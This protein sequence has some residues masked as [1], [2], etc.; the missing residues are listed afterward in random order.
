MRV[1]DILYQ[2]TRRTKRVVEHAHI[3]TFH[4]EFLP[5]WLIMPQFVSD[6]GCLNYVALL[7][8][9]IELPRLCEIQSRSLLK[10][11]TWKIAINENTIDDTVS[12]AWSRF[13]WTYSL[14]K[15]RQGTKEGVFGT[16]RVQLDESSA[17]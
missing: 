15:Q 16:L 14:P 2:L 11:D 5:H 4:G 9:T 1:S 6:I 10:T 8:G 13:C 17:P 12:R 7:N 3:T